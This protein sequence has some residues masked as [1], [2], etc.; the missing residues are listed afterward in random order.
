MKATVIM[1]NC[2]YHGRTMKA[3]PGMSLLL[4]EEGRKILVD[5]GVSGATVDNLVALGVHPREVDALVISHGHWDHTGGLERLL[6][7]ACKSLPVY[8]HPLAFQE[9]YSLSGDQHKHVGIPFHRE[10][11]ASLGAEF[12]WVDMP[13]A[14][15]DKLW[16]S[17]SV[18]R[19]F[20]G[21]SGD[22]N[23]VLPGSAGWVN[24]TVADDMSLFY[25]GE[26]GLTVISGCAH[27]GLRNTVAYGLQVTGCERLHGWIGG[28]HLGMV[29]R[30]QQQMTMEALAA[31]QP[32][33]IA[34][35]HCTG[36][37]MQAELSRR[38]PASFRAM[39][40]GTTLEWN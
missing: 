27:A 24:D 18:P 19:I 4:E 10:S 36:F 29:N 16:V 12:H 6:T 26:Q 11:L 33:F 25:K 38:F 15:T 30:E 23:L 7:A 32:L 2:V 1:D 9:R 14:V 39:A 34:A 22:P 40:V 5:V 35:N 21:E 13:F 28:T 20:P 37:P 31:W 17:G 3:E 8:I